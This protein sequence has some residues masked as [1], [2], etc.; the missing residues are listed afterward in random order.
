MLSH[1][2]IPL[3]HS[4]PLSLSRSLSLSPFLPCQSASVGCA[5]RDRIRGKRLGLQKQKSERPKTH[6]LDQMPEKQLRGQELREG[7]NNE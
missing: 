4:L 2:D 5:D 3:S 7:R 1:P 6:N